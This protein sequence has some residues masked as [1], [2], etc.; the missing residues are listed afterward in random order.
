MLRLWRHIHTEHLIARLTRQLQESEVTKAT[1]AAVSRKYTLS[2]RGPK[3][4]AK[5]QYPI[6][7]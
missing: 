3:F 7:G 1:A 5:N 6:I 2:K 4:S